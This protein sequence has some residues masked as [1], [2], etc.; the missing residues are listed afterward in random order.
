MSFQASFES[1]YLELVYESNLQLRAAPIFFS[2]K[3]SVEKI[4]MARLRI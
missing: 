4:S 1:E 3:L 2:T